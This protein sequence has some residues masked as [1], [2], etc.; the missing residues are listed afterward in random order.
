MA[1]QEKPTSHLPQLSRLPV[2]TSTA[3]TVRP[4]QTGSKQSTT[5]QFQ[6]GSIR[7]PKSRP[8][9]RSK[10]HQQLKASSK[11]TVNSPTINPDTQFAKDRVVGE[12]P[13]FEERAFNDDNLAEEPTTQPEPK[14]LSPKKTRPSLSDRA[15]Q[16][17]S[18]I[19]PSPSPR[20]RQSGFF[21]SESPAIRPP[22]A[23]GISRPVTSAGFYPPL[24]SSRPTSPIKHP[25]L[26]TS[27]ASSP[28]KQST[29]NITR[30]NTNTIS[31]RPEHRTDALGQRTQRFPPR[32]SQPAGPKPSQHPSHEGKPVGGPSKDVTP[33]KPKFKAPAERISNVK[34][35]LPNAGSK[36]AKS[37]IR[38]PRKDTSTSK[39]GNADTPASPAAPKSILKS[40]AALRETI[41]NARKAARA[42]PK[43][44]ADDV[45]KPIDRNRFS[46]AAEDDDQRTDL[47]R[48][49]ITAARTDGK[50]NISSMK[51][52][53]FPKE[54]L[55]MYELDTLT[56]GGPTWYESID[57]IKLNAADNQFEEIE[58]RLFD[59]NAGEDEMTAQSNA[60]I[61]SSLQTLDLHGNRLHSIPSSLRD[62]EHL[63]VLNLSRN[64]LNRPM[65]EIA[66][67]IS[68]IAS[69]RELCLAENHFE[70]PL[71][72]FEDCWNLEVLDLHGNAF[73]SLPEELS[74]CTLLRKLDVSNNKIRSLPHLELASLATLNLS[75]NLFTTDNPLMH[76][77]APNLTTLELSN[78]RLRTL[79]DLSRFPCLRTCV[80][81]DNHI[82]CL[83]VEAARG[84]ET[85]DIRNNDLRSLPAEL[86]LLPGLKQLLVAGNPMRAPRRQVLE[87]STERLMEWLRGRLP[88][89]NEVV[90]SDVETF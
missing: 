30:K 22:S 54:V 36:A 20:R 1:D 11:A 3:R 39:D 7:I 12:Q 41:A 9:V 48:K 25:P 10:P 87:G 83:E 45:V 81:N 84:L 6:S 63:T 33:T 76:V 47:L 60:D 37:S 43:Y 51:L 26:P 90:D 69:L 70:G 85:L 57:L 34:P 28:T 66:D 35:P 71:P 31:S 15:I 80:A 27:R 78:C 52:K 2:R 88:I 79:P 61:F 14:R 42:T 13:G 40:S 21:P 68:C 8:D 5:G 53:A 58:W 23:L 74:Q 75:S 29:I 65:I 55:K 59:G 24:P 44:N 19:P 89:S 38:R 18:S 82:S 49:R 4:D 72:P 77:S 86:S 32:T 73:T 16:T 64:R 50:L 17:L 62:F 46:Q 56:D 67:T